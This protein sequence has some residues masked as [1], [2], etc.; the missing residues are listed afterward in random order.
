[1][2]QT[3]P[4]PF[5]LE[6]LEN[7]SLLSAEPQRAVLAYASVD[8]DHRPAVYEM[9]RDETWSVVTLA[10]VPGSPD[11]VFDPVAWI[12][13]DNGR[14]FAAAASEDGLILYT[15]TAEGLWGQRNLTE[16]V[17]GS[18]P[19]VDE[20]HFMEDA[21]GSFYLIGFTE[22]G[23][24]VRYALS[25]DSSRWTYRNI[26]KADLEF[27]G[28]PIPEI[29][30]DI[31]PYA[32]A[33]NGLNA[34]GVDASGQ[35]WSIWWAPGRRAWAS[36]NLSAATQTATRFTGDLTV[37]TTPWK[38][39]NIAGVGL[40]GNLKVVWWVPKFGGRWAESDLTAAFGGPRLNA[41][42]LTSFRTDAGGLA[43]GGVNIANGHLI[44]YAWTPQ[45]GGWIVTDVTAAAGSAGRVADVRG[46]AGT[47]G[48]WNLLTTEIQAG[49][50]TVARASWRPGVAAW[51]R[52]NVSVAAEPLEDR[53]GLTPGY[54]YTYG[55]RSQQY[56]G[57]AITGAANAAM[58]V[59]LIGT[60]NNARLLFG[61]GQPSGSAFWYDTGS[62]QSY[63][64][65]YGEW[66]YGDNGRYYDPDYYAPDAGPTPQ[67]PNVMDY[68]NYRSSTIPG[69]SIPSFGST[70]QYLSSFDSLSS[71]STGFG[72]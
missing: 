64:S 41:S 43:I 54:G 60:Y 37:Y 40:D 24:A 19:I 66:F 15:R 4:V 51:L 12:D 3:P 16:G 52:S 36:S 71:A 21:R 22:A 29:V 70:L 63:A 8:D 53:F 31:A 46:A 27:T 7:R 57:S 6:A 67:S 47:D 38:G 65:P 1:M 62:Q 20:L 58:L 9:L 48:T 45:S 35:V 59:A 23:D 32:T 30:S 61:T 39:I 34:A 68:G 13:R 18:E 56:F 28:Q 5:A 17:P 26:T 10:N 42:S 2:K 25:N 11:D 44:V 69:S 72:G 14:T 49:N 55:Y 50:V 33:W